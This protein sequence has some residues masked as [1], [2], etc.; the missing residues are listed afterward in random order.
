MDAI[1][2]LYC[3]YFLI[4]ACML[5][6]IGERIVTKS[7]VVKWIIFILSIISFIVSCVMVFIKF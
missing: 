1:N 3:I 2:Q 4:V 5:L 6:Y 7:K